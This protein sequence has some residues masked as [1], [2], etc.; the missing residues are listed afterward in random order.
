MSA[1]L[2]PFGASVLAAAVT[3]AGIYVI[4]HFEA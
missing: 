1:F 4:R 3:T 2:I